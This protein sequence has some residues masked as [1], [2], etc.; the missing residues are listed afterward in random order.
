[1]QIIIILKNL[2]TNNTDNTNNTN[3]NYP[4]NLKY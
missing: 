2:N 4:K 3:N 1:M